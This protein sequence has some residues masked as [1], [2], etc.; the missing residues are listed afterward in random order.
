MRV[1]P[2][3]SL[4]Y[5]CPEQLFRNTVLEEYWL[6]FQ[7]QAFLILCCEPTR[8]KMS[9]VQVTKQQ[10][11]LIWTAP[12]WARSGWFLGMKNWRQPPLSLPTWCTLTKQQSEPAFEGSLR[13]SLWT[14]SSTKTCSAE[15]QKACLWGYK[16][17]ALKRSHKVFWL[18]LCFASLWK[19]AEENDHHSLLGMGVVLAF[20]LPLFLYPLEIKLVFPHWSVRL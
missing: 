15:V 8:S 13:A 19:A 12:A 14:M 16:L 17:L 2:Q 3:I 5:K 9:L 4:F 18:P 7:T 10:K 20:I 6:M 1:F 11:G